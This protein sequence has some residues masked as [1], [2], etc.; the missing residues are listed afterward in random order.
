MQSNFGG[1][2][3]VFLLGS[4]P[5][6]GL[7]IGF[8]TIRLCQIK[9]HGKSVSIVGVAD[10][11]ITERIL[12]KD[13][14]KN[15]AATA[16][17]IREACRKAKPH[18]ITAKKIV[19]TLPETFVFSKTIRL[20]KMSV[21]ELKTSVPNEAAQYLP[22]PLSDVYVDF[23]ILITHPDEPLIDILIAAAPKR[24]VDDYVEMA[25]M[26]DMEL[27]ALETKPIAV[28][29]ALI[30]E[31]SK[32]GI[33]I[34]HI[35]TEL[36]RISIWDRGKIGL[37][38]TAPIGKNQIL[39]YFISNNPSIKNINEIDL[40][41]PIEDSAA[42]P[43]TQIVDAVSEAIRYHQNRG[44]QPSKISQIDI[45]GSAAM[46]KNI[47]SYIQ[48]STKIKAVISQPAYRLGEKIS[49]DLTTAFGLALREG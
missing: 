47:D 7:D 12:D 13:R 44:Y 6:F 37:V 11:P 27:V 38:T 46:I 32:D 21:E 8:E 39:E 10:I 40:N 33:A 3:L 35:G 14:I 17:S 15:K 28:G 48:K 19:S 30:P 29:R 1:E 34:V 9:K 26:A 16:N 20:P 43:L 49:P 31:K 5:V 2:F 18:S 22:I 42:N 41:K 45:C 23:Q 36:S 25:K 4:S 24:L